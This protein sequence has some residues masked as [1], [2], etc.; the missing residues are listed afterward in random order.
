[1]TS[2]RHANWL[3]AQ[4]HRSSAGQEMHFPRGILAR[5]SCRGIQGPHQQ[6]DVVDFAA[7]PQTLACIA[8][9]PRRVCGWGSHAHAPADIFFHGAEADECMS[10]CM[11]HIR[12]VTSLEPWAV[13]GYLYEVLGICNLACTACSPA[14]VARPS[15]ICYM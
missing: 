10:K 8:R 2:R 9:E 1:L 13:V 6:N 15:H 5:Q 14:G 12:A 3:Q 4:L 11:C 7:A